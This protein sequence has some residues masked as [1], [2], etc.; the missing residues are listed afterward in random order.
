MDNDE[1]ATKE[2]EEMQK[3]L[4]QQEKL[5]QKG[6]TQLNKLDAMSKKALQSGKKLD[7]LLK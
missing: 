2:I 3:Q 4:E 1:K 5:I 6:S 7:E